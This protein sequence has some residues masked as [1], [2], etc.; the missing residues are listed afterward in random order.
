MLTKSTFSQ[1]ESRIR[2]LVRKENGSR[3]KTIPSCFSARRDSTGLEAS[4]ASEGITA[5]SGGGPGGVI[6]RLADG[7]TP[8]GVLK[9]NAMDLVEKL[10]P[11]PAD[12]EIAEAV[13]A[14][15]LATASVGVTSVQDMEGSSPATRRKLM[16]V[17]QQ[18]ARRGELT[19]RLDVRWPI[20]GQKELTDLGVEGNFGGDFVRVG[21]VKGFMDGSLGSSTA[22]M[23]EP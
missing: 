11:E 4:G 21:G 14:S 2:S 6:E 3:V 7:K 18:L 13:R 16:R 19:C 9:D 10:I 17:V 1:V 12:D 22:K 20:G 15:M 5:G 8:S 23:F